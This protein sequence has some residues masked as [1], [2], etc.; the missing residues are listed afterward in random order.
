MPI[1]KPL[2]LK[3]LDYSSPFQQDL[4]LKSAWNVKFSLLALL[5]KI[6]SSF[7]KVCTLHGDVCR[8]RQRRRQRLAADAAEPDLERPLLQQDGCS[9]AG[10]VTPIKEEASEKAEEEGQSAPWWDAGMQATLAAVLCLW[11]LKL[12]QQGYVDGESVQR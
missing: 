1:L 2:L 8:R 10:P 7:H 6:V 5:F 4:N 9:S 3:L 12:V 11:A